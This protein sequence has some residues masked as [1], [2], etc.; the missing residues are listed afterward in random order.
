MPEQPNNADVRVDALQL[1]APSSLALGDPQ[2]LAHDIGHALGEALGPSA[3]A[4]IAGM[5][6]RLNEDELRHQPAKAIA[7]AMALQLRNAKEDTR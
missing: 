1:R 3:T 7:R 2:R 5:R 6:L 4:T